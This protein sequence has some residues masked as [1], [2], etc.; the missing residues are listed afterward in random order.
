MYRKY[1]IEL[2]WENPV[3]LNSTLALSA[4]HLVCISTGSDH[5]SHPVNPSKRPSLVGP[6]DANKAHHFYLT[7]A[8]KQQR[9][10]IANPQQANKN[11]L[12]IAT[13]LLSYQTLGSWSQPSQNGEASSYSPPMHWL[14]MMKGISDITDAIVPEEEAW[15]VNFMA[16]EASK[17]DF[18]N[19]TA[20]S[21]AENTQPF[22]DLLDFETYPEPNLDASKRHAYDMALR[23]I[24]GIYRGIQE[25]E[26]PSALF[27]R[28]LCLGLMVPGQFLN[29]I[30]ERRPR[31]LAMLALYCSTAASL[32]YH[33][34]FHG[35]AERELK[36][37]QTLLPPEWQWS[38]SA[39]LRIMESCLSKQPDTT[40]GNEQ[41]G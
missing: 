16:S 40:N 35:M 20:L 22:L 10:A 11:A 15:F 17:L 34:M 25:N 4:W 31:A 29:F 1:A 14:R 12:I 23:Y 13:V 28:L 21:N 41:Q 38:M 33:W 32:D 2:C 7:T 19:E 9:E 30:D 37:L 6:I 24:G 36:G 39:P 26:S 3:L 27:R 18:R 5:R 8:V